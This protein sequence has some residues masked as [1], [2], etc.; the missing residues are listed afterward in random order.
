MCIHGHAYYCVD[1][2]LFMKIGM[3]MGT[4]IDMSVVVKG[5][6]RKKIKIKVCMRVSVHVHVHL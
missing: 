5:N 6:K 4:C 3:C 1:V 2:Y